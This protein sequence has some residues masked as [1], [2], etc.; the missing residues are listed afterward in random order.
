M[1]DLLNK[2]VSLDFIVNP[3]FLYT[4]SFS[5]SVFVYLLGWSRIYPPLSAGLVIFLAVTILLFLSAAIVLMK[6]RSEFIIIQDFKTSLNDIIFLAIILLS[7]LN[8]LYMGYLPV[9]DRSHNYLEFGMPVVDPIVNTLSIFFSVVYFHS[10]LD[11]RK[12]R[13]LV[14]F[15]SILIIQILF[16][17]RSTITWIVISSFFLF[18]LYMRN[19]SLKILAICVIC[20][21]F[22]SYSFGLYGNTR[23]RLAKSFVLNDLGASDSFK[24]S[25]ISY[26]HY[27]TYLYISSPLANLQENINKR[28]VNI[29]DGKLKDFLFYCL[30]PE[31]FTLR[32]E[33]PLH[34]TPPSCYLICPNLIAGSFY[35]ISFYLMGW[36]GMIIMFIFLF[37]F[38]L[39]GLFVIRKWNTY[40]LEAL[41]LLSA[42]VSLLIFSNFLNRL[43]VIIMLFVYPV[44]FHFIS[45][46]NSRLQALSFR[47]KNRVL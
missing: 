10:F 28:D 41:S 13:F 14:Y 26:N 34:L 21:P 9:T 5:V 7:V 32:L 23:S 42:A 15:F 35:M 24:N 20:L 17:R 12:K 11:T 39:L 22:F 29:K 19:V 40:N 36:S 1:T 46:Q 30:I 4:L 38:L 27:M 45:K 25:G 16:Y 44:I 31:S 8:V 6:N 47:K 33:K 2:K 3:F 18:L 43:D 37:A